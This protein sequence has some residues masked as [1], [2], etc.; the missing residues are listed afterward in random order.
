VV[1]TDHSCQ[2]DT[3]S[4]ATSGSPPTARAA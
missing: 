2:R 3:H 1:C 4:S